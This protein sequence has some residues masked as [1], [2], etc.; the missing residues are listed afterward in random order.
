MASC[1]PGNTL[2]GMTSNGGQFFSGT[3]FEINADGSNFKVLHT[4][5]NQSDGGHP[6]AGLVRVGDSLYGSTESGGSHSESV[7]FRF[8]LPTLTWTGQ[9][10]GAA[11]DF[12]AGNWND[13]QI[14]AR[15]MRTLI[16]SRS[17]TRRRR[18]RCW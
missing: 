14:K 7:L 12:A 15:C 6:I 9:G 8:Q 17:M 16:P 2:Y 1:S 13:G 4:F 11:W 5:T 3:L 18:R 10:S